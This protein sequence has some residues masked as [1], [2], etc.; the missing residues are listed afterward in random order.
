MITDDIYNSMVFDGL[1]YHKIGQ[2][3]AGLR[4]RV[5]F[6]DSISKTYGMPG[7]RCGFMAGPESVAKGA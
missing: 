7:W 4:E 3:A 2:F 5:I 1:G 6:V